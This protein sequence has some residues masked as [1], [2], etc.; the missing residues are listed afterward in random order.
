MKNQTF[1]SPKNRFR[2]EFRYAK[3]VE[4]I[5]SV[6]SFGVNSIENLED[7]SLFQEAKN[8][9][10]GSYTIRENHSTYPDFDWEIIKSVT[11][12]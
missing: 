7:S 5:G 4:D 9:G 10:P 11:Y 12:E 8:R 3:P 6:Y 1:N 2:I